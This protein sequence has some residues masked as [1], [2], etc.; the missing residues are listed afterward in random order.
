[1]ASIQDLV[2]QSVADNSSGGMFFSRVGGAEDGS[3]GIVA[4]Y[5]IGADGNP[6]MGNGAQRAEFSLDGHFLRMGADENDSIGSFAKDTV[7]DLAPVAGMVAAGVGF[8]QFLAGV[9]GTAGAAGATVAEGAVQG[10]S[11]NA[12]EAH[13]ASGVSDSAI[14]SGASAGG[15]SLQ[16]VGNGLS[17]AKTAAG[18]LGTGA[19]MQAA[20]AAIAT[21]SPFAGRGNVAP[22]YG[23]QTVDQADQGAAGLAADLAPYATGNGGGQIVATEASGENMKPLI[24]AIVAALGAAFLIHRKK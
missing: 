9:M 12:L 24:I 13:I 15:F 23:P 4:G 20:H 18:I 6:I 10:N 17:V 2:K 5:K 21:S 1:L 8:G 7:K 3:G 16:S 22:V 14:A 11:I 19:A